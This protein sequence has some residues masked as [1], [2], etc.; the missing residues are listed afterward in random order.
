MHILHI[1]DI[2]KDFPMTIPKLEKPESNIPG[3]IADICQPALK[4]NSA[5]AEKRNRTLTD[6]Y[7]N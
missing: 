1:N 2:I 5:N 7:A 4:E 3:A 6:N